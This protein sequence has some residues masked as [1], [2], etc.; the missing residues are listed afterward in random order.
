MH[1]FQNHVMWKA[2]NWY[3]WTNVHLG[4]HQWKIYRAL[5]ANSLHIPTVFNWSV[6][7]VLAIY[8][9]ILCILQK[10]WRMEIQDGVGFVCSLVLHI[11]SCHM[12]PVNFLFSSTVGYAAM[13]CNELVNLPLVLYPEKNYTSSNEW[14]ISLLPFCS[15]HFFPFVLV[16][17]SVSSSFI[18]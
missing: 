3:F 13:V 6:W 15:C 12:H 8:T 2:T 18:F 11:C 14:S 10:I 7:F 5:S 9:S 16:T 4:L 17:F 1:E